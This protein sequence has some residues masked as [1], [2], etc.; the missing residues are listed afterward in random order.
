MSVLTEK[1]E[2]LALKLERYL[3]EDLCI[4]EIEDAGALVRSLVARVEDLEAER[5]YLIGQVVQATRA[6]PAGG[7]DE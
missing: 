2:A 1:E 4:Q 6:H 7:E 5:E 3:P